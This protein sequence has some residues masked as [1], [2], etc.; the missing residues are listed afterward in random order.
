[1][2]EIRDQVVDVLEP[3]AA[4]AFMDGP[5]FEANPIGEKFDPDALVAAFERGDGIDEF[6]FRSDQEVVPFG[7]SR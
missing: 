7:V 3:D 5:S 1:M 2:I 6:I 4:N